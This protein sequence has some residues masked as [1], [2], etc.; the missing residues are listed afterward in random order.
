MR[1][2]HRCFFFT[3]TIAWIFKIV[4]I[5]VLLVI[6]VLKILVALADLMCCILG[7]GVSLQ[8]QGANDEKQDNEPRDKVS[9]GNEMSTFHGTGGGER[10]A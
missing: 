7:A 6:V 9:S 3:L 4:V 2:Q 1:S 10:P 5:Q 8:A